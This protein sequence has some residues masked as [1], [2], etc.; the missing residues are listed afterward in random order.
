MMCDAPTRRSGYSWQDGPRTAS[1]MPFQ[2]SLTTTPFDAGYA[3]APHS[4][5]TTNFANLA[6]HPDGRAQ[7]IAA[8]LARIERRFHGL[9]R[10]PGD[11]ARYRIG[12]EI[13]TI[14]IRFP[15]GPDAWFPMT[16]TLRCRVFDRHEGREL[17]GL[18]GGNYSSFVRDYDFNILRPRIAAGEATKEEAE[19]FGQLHGLLFRLQFRHH[20]PAGV[21]DEPLVIAISVASGRDYHRQHGEHRILGHEYVPNGVESAT[22]RY[23][24]AMGLGVSYFMPPGCRAPLAFYHEPGDLLTRPD[25]ALAALVAIMDT[26]ESIYRPEIYLTRKPA[27]AVF[28]ADLGNRDHDPP[29]AIYDRVERDTKLGR[30][31]AE[32]ARDEFLE[33]NAAAIRRLM[34]EHA[35]LGPQPAGGAGRE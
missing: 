26:F 25:E 23:F 1:I 30:A 24:A 35:S 7:R 27:G 28:R 17:A 2:I 33:P 16:E 9:L 22:T 14:S 15:D 6:K 29:P 13:L 32:R 4:R 10:E 12:L 20:H 8:T 18:T 3:P 11:S 31:Q 19:T 5:L 34:A 21:L